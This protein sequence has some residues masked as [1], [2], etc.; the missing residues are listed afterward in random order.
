[1]LPVNEEALRFLR[2]IRAILI[3]RKLPV[4]RTVA[5]ELSDEGVRLAHRAKQNADTPSAS[6]SEVVIKEL[7]RAAHKAQR[8]LSKYRMQRADR[9]DVVHD[10]LLWCLENRDNYSLTTT[11]D[12][13]FLNAVRNMYQKHR[14]NEVR[15]THAHL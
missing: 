2:L 12:T 5:F 9:E 13:W 6:P 10:A 11:L 8:F 7:A 1:M 15:T 14:R 3:E 4:S